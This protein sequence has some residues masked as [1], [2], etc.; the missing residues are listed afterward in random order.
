M[1]IINK[2]LGNELHF[3]IIYSYILEYINFFK[4]CNFNPIILIEKLV[5]QYDCQN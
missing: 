1:S 2:Y 5:A 3:S 4:H